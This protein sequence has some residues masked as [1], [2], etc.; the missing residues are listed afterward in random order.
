MRLGAI[1]YAITDETVAPIETDVITVV[2]TNIFL[3][4]AE[5]FQ[6]HFQLKEHF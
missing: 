1:R 3:A 2:P 6:Q 4:R 5:Q